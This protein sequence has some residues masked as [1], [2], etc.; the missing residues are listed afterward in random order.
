MHLGPVLVAIQISCMLYLSNL[1][2]A[3]RASS[4]GHLGSLPAHSSIRFRISSCSSQA[5]GLKANRGLCQ[6]HSRLAALYT[7]RNQQVRVLCHV[8]NAPSC[9]ECR[10]HARQ[11]FKKARGIF[12]LAAPI[13]SLAACVAHDGQHSLQK[14]YHMRALLNLQ[15]ITAHHAQPHRAPTRDSINTAKTGQAPKQQHCQ[16]W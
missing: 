11:E 6:E 16:K 13:G 9:Q 10:L 12:T 4:P 7:F 1:L 14:W 8:K 2:A 5:R 15:A 3:C